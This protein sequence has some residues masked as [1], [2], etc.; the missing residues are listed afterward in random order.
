MT[1]TLPAL[2]ALGF[3][4]QCKAL[5][6]DLGEGFDPTTGK[7]TRHG[8]Q[9]RRWVRGFFSG[10]ILQVTVNIWHV[11]YVLGT[12]SLVGLGMYSSITR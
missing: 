1:Y 10:G 3:D 8:G 7:V 6:P 2:F 9:L 5:R 11:I 4:I 12:L